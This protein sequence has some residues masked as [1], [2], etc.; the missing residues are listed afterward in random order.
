VHFNNRAT[1]N[2]KHLLLRRYLRFRRLS[3]LL[4]LF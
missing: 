4:S 1:T 2:K 3:R